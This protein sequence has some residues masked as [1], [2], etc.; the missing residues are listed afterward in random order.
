MDYPWGWPSPGSYLSQG[1]FRGGVGTSRVKL[2]PTG[3][4]D[5]ALKPPFSFP[6][7]YSEVPEPEASSSV[8]WPPAGTPPPR[9]SLPVGIGGCHHSSRN[10]LLRITD[11]SFRMGGALTWR[12]PYLAT[13]K[14]GDAQSGQH[15][16]FPPWGSLGGSHHMF[17]FDLGQRPGTGRYT[18]PQS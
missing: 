3:T 6:Y 10:I 15:A 9:S 16:D 11:C 18:S 1:F 5:M 14:P 17:D 13:P 4:G 7:Y 2:L 8:P 12:R